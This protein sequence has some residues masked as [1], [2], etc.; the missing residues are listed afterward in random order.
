MYFKITQNNKQI[1]EQF[2]V[3]GRL[4]LISANSVLMSRAVSL[5]DALLNM[6]TLRCETC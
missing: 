1:E 4:L 2:Y 3:I 5:T 6:K